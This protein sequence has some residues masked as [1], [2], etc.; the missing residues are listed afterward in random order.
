MAVYRI[1]EHRFF[2]SDL[3]TTPL[4]QNMTCFEEPNVPRPQSYRA[5][6]NS[7][8]PP[9]PGKTQQAPVDRDPFPHLS[10]LGA[11]SDADKRASSNTHSRRVS[12]ASDWQ[13]AA[14]TPSLIQ[15][16]D[17]DSSTVSVSAAVREE[18]Y[19]PSKQKSGL[20]ARAH[21]NL[22]YRRTG[23]TVQPHLA[24]KEDQKDRISQKENV[25]QKQMHDQKKNITARKSTQEVTS[26]HSAKQV[27]GN[28][29]EQDLAPIGM[30]RPNPTAVANLPPQTHKLVHGQL[31]ILQS[32]SFLIDF[33][34][35]ERRKGNKGREV[36]LINADGSQVRLN[37]RHGIYIHSTKMHADRDP[38][39]TTSQLSVLF[40][41][42]RRHLFAI[43]VA[44]RVLEAICQC[45]SSY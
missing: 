41:R 34:E 14:N 6:K 40:S 12:L 27:D 21:P 17:S 15:D 43:S 45:R 25:P 28:L 24:G 18:A 22:A 1:P 8:A 35:G 32:R 3:T 5:L 10:V 4:Q 9:S 13:A 26:S 42:A 36:L 11:L 38:R 19:N 16:L 23:A 7:A 2:C 44:C 31:T 20:F 29:G 30:S 33:R 37:T 39:R